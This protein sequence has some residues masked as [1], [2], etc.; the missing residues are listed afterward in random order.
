MTNEPRPVH[1]DLDRERGLTLVWDDGSRAFLANAVLRRESPSAD[2]RELR[3]EMARNPFTVLPATS[4]DG[5]LRV[6]V[7][8]PVGHYALRIRFSDGHDTGIYT[9]RY[10]HELCAKHGKPPT[11]A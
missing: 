5:P 6:D 1:I 7:V 3:A 9:W 10:L 2:A 4:S 11:S 8:E